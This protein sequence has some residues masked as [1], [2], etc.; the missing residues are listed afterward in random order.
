MDRI[1][2][3][4]KQTLSQL[5]CHKKHFSDYWRWL[6]RLGVGKKNLLGKVFTISLR[7]AIYYFPTNSLKGIWKVVLHCSKPF[8][9]QWNLWKTF[10][11]L[12][13]LVCT[14]SSLALTTESVNDSWTKTGLNRLFPETKQA[15]MDDI[16][17]NVAL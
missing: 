8:Q 6:K 11:L 12:G 13:A 16:V 4:L 14:Q 5:G 17:L 2:D 15:E 10:E 3:T 7:N 9:H 1:K